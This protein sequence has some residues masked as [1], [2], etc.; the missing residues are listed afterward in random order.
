MNAADIE[1]LHK[2][3]MYFTK[4]HEN[5]LMEDVTVWTAELWEL[6]A[7]DCRYRRRHTDVSLQ[8]THQIVQRLMAHL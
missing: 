7:F 2:R 3:F 5:V 1:S 4:Q 6:F 8:E